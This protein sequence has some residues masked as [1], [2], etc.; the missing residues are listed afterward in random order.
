MAK[1]NPHAP[2]IK[3]TTAIFSVIESNTSVHSP[4]SGYHDLNQGAEAKKHSCDTEANLEYEYSTLRGA[5]THNTIVQRATI[6]DRRTRSAEDKK[7]PKN[8]KAIS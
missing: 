5:G 8:Q 7:Q 2:N 6:K 3:S 1:D 4:Y